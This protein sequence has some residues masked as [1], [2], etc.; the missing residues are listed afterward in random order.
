MRQDHEAKTKKYNNLTYQNLSFKTIRTILS[1]WHHHVEVSRKQDWIKLFGRKNG[2]YRQI[3][4]RISFVQYNCLFDKP[5]KLQ[6]PVCITAVKAKI[7]LSE[8]L[9]L[10]D[11]NLKEID[12]YDNNRHSHNIGIHKNHTKRLVETVRVWEALESFSYQT[13]ELFGFGREVRK[14]KQLT[15]LNLE[16]TRS[17][18]KVDYWSDFFTSLQALTH[19]QN[20]ALA[21]LPPQG[22]YQLPSTIRRLSLSYYGSGGRFLIHN[23]PQIHSVS[24]AQLHLKGDFEATVA[25]LLGCLKSDSLHTIGV[26]FQRINDFSSMLNSEIV[27]TTVS[28]LR[29]EYRGTEDMVTWFRDG[30]VQFRALDICSLPHRTMTALLSQL[31][32]Q[33]SLQ[34]VT[35]DHLDIMNSKPL[36][37]ISKI[38][39]ISLVQIRSGI[40][41]PKFGEL[42]RF[43]LEIL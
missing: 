39:L 32:Y 9:W 40:V 12:L 17:Q 42:Y 27:H 19:L 10:E 20:L 24:L 43:R 7:Q 36:E 16:I 13:Y 14:L 4:T 6:Y 25:V 11:W 22:L 38:P 18:K 34:V 28:S 33:R 8:R 41:L 1:F 31:K 5:F 15:S 2:K 29:I 23:L 3:Y 35:F 30:Q 21:F 37:L 26:S